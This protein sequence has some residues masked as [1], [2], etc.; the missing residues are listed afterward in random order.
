M[1]D[2][3]IE[4]LAGAYTDLCDVLQ[5][6]LVLFAGGYFDCDDLVFHRDRFQ[7]DFFSKINK[8]QREESRVQDA[9]T[10]YKPRKN[11]DC[12]RSTLHR[13]IN[14]CRPLLCRRF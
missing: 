10:R 6:K 8:V 7:R 1:F 14:V 13:M 3:G 2:L 9:G 11:D 5:S 12:T 4:Y